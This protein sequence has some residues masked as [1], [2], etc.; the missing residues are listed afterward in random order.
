LAGQLVGSRWDGWPL[1]NIRWLLRA[2]VRRGLKGLFASLFAL[3]AALAATLAT[4]L[5]ARETHADQ[6]IW[7]GG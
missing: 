3:L 1:T 7:V 5:G 2:I 4:A 6:R